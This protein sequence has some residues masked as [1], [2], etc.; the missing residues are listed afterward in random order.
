MPDLTAIESK[1][2]RVK[3]MLA[4]AVI[5]L[6]V[7]AWFSV[8]WQL[9]DMLATLTQAT[10]PNFAEI[11]ELATRWAPGDP[12]AF[13]LKA[14]AGEDTDASI[15]ALEAAV[16][17][18]P[19]D[20]RWR[21]DLGRAYE[22]GDQFE[23]AEIQ[24]KKA[25]ALAP[26]YSSAR[27][28]LGNFYLRKEQPDA[29]LAELKIAAENNPTY[30]EQVYSL[31]WDFSGR[32]SVQLEK[33]AGGRPDMLARLAYFF[34]ARGRAEDSL[35]NWNRLSEDD[36]AK[37]TPIARSIALGL[38]DQRHFAQALEFARQYGAETEAQPNAI[39][40]GSFE[41]TIGENNESRFG[42]QIARNDPKFDASPE[43]RVKRDGNR[44]LRATFKG[45]NKPTLA[46]IS[47]TVVV[48]PGR[49]YKLR[50]WVRTENLRSAGLPLV[51]IVNANDDKPLA[52]SQVFPSGTNDWQELTVEVTTPIGCSGIAIRTIRAY[53]GEDCPI[54]GIFWYDDFAI[55][56]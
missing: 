14:S 40:N 19:S 9:G 42:W 55:G 28:Q 39:A 31:V 36:K 25:V 16:R 13:S 54:T 44:S 12:A 48:E 26:S 11:A 20:Y 4:T 27:W 35:R 22:Q 30:R 51:E 33:I 49:K 52:R 1:T 24:L 56:D 45:F 8:R 5:V 37:N 46:N 32:S 7:L 3:L 34:A 6:V 15:K 18:A 17:R 10:D 21:I 38:F 53:C 29:A 43:G 2:I 23:K 47:Q 50:F 41:K